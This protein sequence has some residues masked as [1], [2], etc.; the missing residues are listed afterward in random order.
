MLKRMTM[1]HRPVGRTRSQMRQSGLVGQTGP[2]IL[3]SFTIWPVTTTPPLHCHHHNLNSIIFSANLLS[4]YNVLQHQS[5]H[6]QLQFSSMKIKMY[7]L[8]RCHNIPFC[9]NAEQ[10]LDNFHRSVLPD[11][12]LPIDPSSQDSIL[13]HAIRQCHH[14]PQHHFY[15]HC[16][17]G[18]VSVFLL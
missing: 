1:M 9:S 16:I 14:R 2:N 13:G 4:L 10:M 17:I 18:H 11:P 15:H 6:L 12:Y 5:A 7:N 8:M 3:L